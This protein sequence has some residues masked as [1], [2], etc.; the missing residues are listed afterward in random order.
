MS[1]FAITGNVEMIRVAEAV[2]REKGLKQE[3][4]MSALKE[5]L[6]TVARR[7]YGHDLLIR[8]EVSNKSGMISL[9]RDMNVVE[10]ITLDPEAEDPEA[11]QAKAQDQQILIKDAKVIDKG[12]EVGGVITDSL[13]PIDFGRV[14]SQSFKQ[15]L[16]QKI[17]E[18][19][20]EKQFE[21]F[22]DR[23]GEIVTGVVK[24]IEFGNYILDFG[25]TE[26]ILPRDQ[27]IPR[28]SYNAGDRIRAY[29]V[30]VRREQRGPQIILS[31]THPNFMKELFTQE[32]PEIYDG[33]VEIKMVVRD[34][35]SRAKIAV[36]SDD[37]NIDPV[38]AC[39]GPRGSRV[40]AVY[41]E[42]Q[43]EKIDIVQYSHDLAT[44]TV[45]AL[46]SKTKEFQVE[47][48]RIIFDEDRNLIQAIVP[49]D[50]LSLAIGRRGQNVRLAAELV[51][52]NIDV[53]GE[54]EESTKRVE[55]F[56]T[57]STLFAEAMNVEEV[58]G[59][60]L[61]SEGFNSLE[62]VAYIEAHELESIEGFDGEL[63][64]E[65]QTRA[66][67]YLE[68]Q[69]NAFEQEMAAENV[70][71]GIL[72]LPHLDHD[73]VRKL[74]IKDFKKLDDIADLAS[75]EFKEHFPEIELSEEQINEIIMAARAH[76]FEDQPATAK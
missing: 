19:E 8:A 57:L 24:R 49:D 6:E 76:W 14:T 70:E 71:E 11:E 72:T 15:V 56:N 22:K 68:E 16:M 53:I 2:S 21:D 51:G 9:F 37:S 60:L 7:K 10:A 36:Y 4:V 63:V 28:E 32:V 39:I 69:Q 38:G 23:V 59:Q 44:L 58:I 47:V 17:R 13:P 62:E 73:A 54:T 35:G 64:A 20:R 29:I 27:I 1:Q 67:E 30:D 34:P 52:W 48:S 33:I 61:V 31:R 65:L 45:N 40:T 74:V 25:K 12:V 55:E 42:L 43:G 18:A 26:T 5:A 41:N 66:K 3:V 75:D 50:H 46:A